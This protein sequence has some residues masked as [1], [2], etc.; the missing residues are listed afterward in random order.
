MLSVHRKGAI[1]GFCCLFI[2]P[3]PQGERIPVE[4]PLICR[5]QKERWS[6]WSLR[7][8]MEALPE[9][10]ADFLKR[11]GV[12]IHQDASVKRLETTAAGG[13]Q[14]GKKD[15]VG[16]GPQMRLGMALVHQQGDVESSFS[17]FG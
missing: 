9:A 6:Q 14:V 10:L 2:L 12:E 13:W 1:W 15:R 8:G 4:S 5:A 16:K 17:S 7:S 3:V 11:R